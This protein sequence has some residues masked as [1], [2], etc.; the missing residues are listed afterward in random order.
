MDESGTRMAGLLIPDLIN[1]LA[2]VRGLHTSVPLTAVT[3]ERDDREGT[4]PRAVAVQRQ[5]GTS[6]SPA[7]VL[8]CWTV[9]YELRPAKLSNPVPVCQ[10]RD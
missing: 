4:C 10:L 5:P 1:S 9:C 7:S 3:L 8:C 2:V 6:L